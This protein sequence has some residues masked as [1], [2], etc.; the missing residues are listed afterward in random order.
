MDANLNQNKVIKCKISNNRCMNASLGINTITPAS[1]NNNECIGAGTT[2][3]G[4]QGI[5]GKDGKDGEAATISIGYVSTGAAG[6]DATVVNSGT[7]SAAVF[8]FVIP[9]GEKGETGANATI[10]GATASVDNNVGVPSVSVTA[11]GTEAAR[12]FD[13]AFTNLKGANGES[14]ILPYGTSST[15]AET[16]QK[17]VSIPSITTLTAGQVIVVQPSVTSTVADS[18]LKLNSFPAYPMKYNGANIT[19]STDSIVWGGKLPITVYI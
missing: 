9:R 14:G 12:T 15:A 17:E 10:T 6:T 19:T 5:P 4:L 3:R 11:G 8:D 18:T 7:S 13:F 2:Q 16:V 1:I